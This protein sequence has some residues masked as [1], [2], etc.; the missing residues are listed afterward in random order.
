MDAM[1]KTNPRIG[2]PRI[3]PDFPAGNESQFVISYFQH[4]FNGNGLLY[5][6][7]QHAEKDHCR[8]R[9]PA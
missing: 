1:K 9:Q 5:K 3:R 2:F 4:D 8:K 7:G 6:G